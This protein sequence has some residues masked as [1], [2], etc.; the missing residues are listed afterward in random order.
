MERLH[1][2]RHPDNASTSTASG[3]EPKSVRWQRVCSDKYFTTLFFY[4]VRM[5]VCLQML[6]ER[7]GSVFHRSRLFVTL[8]HT[9]KLCGNIH[10]LT[11]FCDFRE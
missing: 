1:I 9:H 8:T 2:S 3:T 11:W 5:M 10:I 4:I 7:I 6:P